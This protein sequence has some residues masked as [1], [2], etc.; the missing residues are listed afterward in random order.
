MKTFTESDK[1]VIEASINITSNANTKI[2][3]VHVEKED[4]LAGDYSS[5][6]QR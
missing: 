6:H 2:V 1:I 5:A 3:A 4:I